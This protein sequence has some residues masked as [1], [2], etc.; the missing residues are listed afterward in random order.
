MS[1]YHAVVWMDHT[2]AHVLSFDREHVEGQ[3]IRSRSHHKHQGKSG[4]ATYFPAI[5]AALGG[6]HEVLLTGPGQARGHEAAVTKLRLRRYG[7]GPGHGAALAAGVV[8]LRTIARSDGFAHFPAGD[9]VHQ[10][11]EIVRFIPLR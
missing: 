7:R 5:S 11:G 8:P 9:R 10:A 4:D 2:E 6:H 1:T 3:K